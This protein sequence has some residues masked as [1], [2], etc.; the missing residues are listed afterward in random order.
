MWTKKSLSGLAW[1]R[2]PP[3]RPFYLDIRVSQ[4]YK[5]IIILIIPSTAKIIFPRRNYL[6]ETLFGS[7]KR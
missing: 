5:K 6:R 7:N 3:L 1:S 4:K 2:D